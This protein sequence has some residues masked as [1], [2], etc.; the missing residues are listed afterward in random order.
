MIKGRV[1]IG[2]CKYFNAYYINKHLDNINYVFLAYN[3][4]LFIHFGSN[5]IPIFSDLII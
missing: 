4:S 1:D 3:H 2:L 5:S